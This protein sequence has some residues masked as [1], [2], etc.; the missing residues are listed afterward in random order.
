MALAYNL[1]TMDKVTYVTLC[2][3]QK[4]FRGKTSPKMPSAKYFNSKL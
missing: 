4:N 3:T 2:S 1:S